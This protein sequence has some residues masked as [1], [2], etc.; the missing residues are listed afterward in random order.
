MVEKVRE[1]T[2]RKRGTGSIVRCS[3]C[4]V[5]AGFRIVDGKGEGRLVSVDGWEKFLNKIRWI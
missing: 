1:V 2:R 3:W 5:G 4:V